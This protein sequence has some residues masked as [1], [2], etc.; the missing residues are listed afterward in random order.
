MRFS[1]V[2]MSVAVDHRAN[3]PVQSLDRV[4]RRHPPGTAGNDEKQASAVRLRLALHLILGNPE[5]LNLPFRFAVST[6]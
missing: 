6:E 4:C 3:R 1:H 2:K 5:V